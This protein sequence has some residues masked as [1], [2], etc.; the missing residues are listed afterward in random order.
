MVEQEHAVPGGY[1]DDKRQVDRCGS[2]PP[3]LVDAEFGIA[4]WT[5]HHSTASRPLEARNPDL[6]PAGPAYAFVEASGR[7]DRPVG[8]AHGICQQCRIIEQTLWG[9]HKHS[10]A[11]MA[12]DR[13]AGIASH[14]FGD[15]DQRKAMS[16][17]KLHPESSSLDGTAGMMPSHH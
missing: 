4:I 17:M 13:Y 11:F 9:N 1:A 7:R 2:H 3:R 10:S 6:A 8:R 5:A 16:A 14:C 12:P 15:P